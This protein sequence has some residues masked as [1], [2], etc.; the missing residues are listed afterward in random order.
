MKQEEIIH[1]ISYKMTK[2]YTAF[3]MHELFYMRG[4]TS[5]IN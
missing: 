3:N 4:M 1:K 2:Q 5:Q